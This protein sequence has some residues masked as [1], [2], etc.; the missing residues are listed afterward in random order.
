MIQIKH[1]NLKKICSVYSN[2]V[3]DKL[4]I[5]IQDLLNLNDL[6]NGSSTI[7]D[8]AVEGRVHQYNKGIQVLLNSKNDVVGTT[9]EL[10]SNLDDIR[11]N[12]KGFQPK[13]NKT[14]SCLANLNNRTLLLKIISSYP[15]DLMRIQKTVLTKLKCKKNDRLIKHLFSYDNFK[16]TFIKDIGAELG[17]IVCPYC[18]RN[19][20]TNVVD[21]TRIVGPTYD[22]FFDKASEPMLAI[23]F[24]NLIPSCYICNSNLKHSK[25]FTLKTHLHPYVNQM[26]NDAV[27]D[28]ELDTTTIPEKKK[29]NFAPRINVK[30]KKNSIQYIRLEG[31]KVKDSGSINV[32]KLREIYATHNDVVEE[33]HEKFD[34]NSKVYSNSISDILV[35]LKSNELE[36]Y[37]FHFNNYFIEDD[38]NK[39]PL[40]KLTKDIYNK[41]KLVYDNNKFYRTR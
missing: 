23:S 39:R 27:F 1:K 35:Q 7:D 38:F 3:V 5:M 2:K 4:L 24:Y 12:V 26:G 29:I 31:N 28:F 34:A 15:K 17:V 13:L 6:I 33:I 25:S 32:F 9:K 22:H 10:S 40:S 11:V 41:M 21:K 36:F 14:L 18:N 37:R 16:D 20:I 30:A 8:K 19:F